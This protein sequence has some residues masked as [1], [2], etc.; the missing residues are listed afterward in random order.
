[1]ADYSKILWKHALYCELFI[2]F[3]SLPYLKE[4][5]PSNKVYTLKARFLELSPIQNNQNE[6]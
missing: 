5:F 1:M 4:I 3:I 6:G 2:D